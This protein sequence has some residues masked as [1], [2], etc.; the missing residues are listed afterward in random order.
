[1]TEKK[2]RRSAKET[3]EFAEQLYNQKKGGKKQTELAKEHGISKT[4]VWRLIEKYKTS[5][6]RKDQNGCRDFEDKVL[7]FLDDEAKK[8]DMVKVMVFAGELEDKNYIIVSVE[9]PE[10][11]DP[12]E[13]D[14]ELRYRI[15][16]S[17]KFGFATEGFKLLEESDNE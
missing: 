15:R 6:F 14:K 5:K 12:A 9:N 4:H 3:L 1:M 8:V 17:L 7:G 13:Y 11:T 2:R 16:K 10:L